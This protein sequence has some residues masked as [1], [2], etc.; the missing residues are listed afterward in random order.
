MTYDAFKQEIISLLEEKISEEQSLKVQE[1]LKNNDLVLDG[2]SIYHPSVNISPTIYLNDYYE[3]AKQGISV[4][5]IAEEIF[6]R[7]DQDDV[8]GEMDMS[9]LLNFSRVK[10]HIIYKLVNMRMNQKLLETVPFVPYLDLAVVFSIRIPEEIISVGQSKDTDISVMIRNDM[11]DIWRITPRE[12]LMY[13]RRNTPKLC[14][15]KVMSFMQM[16]K[17][18]LGEMASEDTCPAYVLT[19]E[20]Q[21]HGASVLLYKGLLKKCAGISEQD[22]VILPSSIHELILLPYDGGFSLEELTEMVHQVNASCVAPEEILSD[23]VY[24]Y[25]HRTNRIHYEYENVGVVS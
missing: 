15:A 12:L 5:E 6:L 1:V 8:A 22:L 13:A 20:S 23:H 19:N 18:L 17:P 3:K 4:D 25:D 11:L 24:V 7:L 21:N 14:P 10:D 2:V 9:F 16:M